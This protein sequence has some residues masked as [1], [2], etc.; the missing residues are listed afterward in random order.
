MEV[1]LRR[2]GDLTDVA[3]VGPD[4]ELP[5]GRLGVG[6]GDGPGTGRH[7]AVASYRARCEP[8]WKLSRAP[9]WVPV[10]TT[11]SPARQ[12]VRVAATASGCCV[13]STRSERLKVVPSALVC[14]VVSRNW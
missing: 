3:V 9:S 12:R 5:T 11:L 13:M 7:V 10:P 8:L 6:A 14:V 2:H 1:V 4:V